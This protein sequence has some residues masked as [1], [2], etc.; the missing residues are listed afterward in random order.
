MI[1]TATH[2]IYC[3]ASRHAVNARLWVGVCKNGS[4]RTSRLIP[5]KTRCV[6]GSPYVLVFVG[7]SLCRLGHLSPFSPLF[8][9]FSFAP[10]FCAPFFSG[11][12]SR[13]G[14]ESRPQ[15]L[16]IDIARSIIMVG[17]D[18][19]RERTAM[20][21]T[22]AKKPEPPASPGAAQEEVQEAG[23]RPL[24]ESDGSNTV[25]LQRRH[26]DSNRCASQHQR[27]VNCEL[28]RPHR[29]RDCRWRVL[30]VLWIEACRQ[31]D[32]TLRV[33]SKVSNPYPRTH[34]RKMGF[35]IGPRDDA[36]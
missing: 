2:S 9:L 10:C 6:P 30:N 25:D 17:Q 11:L 18:S 3:A 22:K 31:I 20:A 16:A 34:D 32:E 36:S 24:Q 23:W 4:R 5:V 15:G 26:A 27:S 14:I 28:Y 13:Y 8:R 19:A 12:R 21:R 35:R 7:L 29:R 1:L 33:S